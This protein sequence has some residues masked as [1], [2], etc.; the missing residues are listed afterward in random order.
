MDYCSLVL[1]AMD[2]MM[3]LCKGGGFIDQIPA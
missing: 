2:L 1:M 3:A